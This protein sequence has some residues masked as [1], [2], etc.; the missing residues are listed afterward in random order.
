MTQVRQGARPTRSSIPELVEATEDE[1]IDDCTAIPQQ[2]PGNAKTHEVYFT[3]TD[4][5]NG[6][7]YSDQTG[8]FPC[9]SN[10]SNKYL[11]IFYV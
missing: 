1:I 6:L 4:A 9:T 10:R 5:G 7:V 11:S 2:E 8:R 3:A